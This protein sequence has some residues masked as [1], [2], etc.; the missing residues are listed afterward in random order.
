MSGPP[1]F[2]QLA[3]RVSE[4]NFTAHDFDRIAA[5]AHVNY[6]VIAKIILARG[7]HKNPVWTVHFDALLNE[8]ALLR[9][10]HSMRPHPRSR[11]SRRRPRSRVL[12]VVKEHS[13]VQAGRR[14]DGFTGHEVE[15][16][17]ACFRQV[18]GDVARSTRNFWITAKDFKGV[19]VKGTPVDTVSIG[20][21]GSKSSTCNPAALATASRSC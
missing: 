17:P 19:M 16:L 15:K 18:F 20:S 5:D 7:S 13:G 11:A 14:I 21:D 10:S 3:S 12:T 2:P 4:E 1:C 9:F 6:T 8:Y